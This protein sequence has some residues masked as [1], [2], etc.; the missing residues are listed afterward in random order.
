MTD[1]PLDSYPRPWFYRPEFY[2]PFFIFPPVWSVLTLR[3]PWNSNVLMGG[4]A[5]FVLAASVVLSFNWGYRQGNWHNLLIFLPGLLLT[6]AT[7]VQWQAHLAQHGPP[8]AAGNDAADPARPPAVTGP[9]DGR[10]SRPSARR[11]PRRRRKG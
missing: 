9:G 7:Q 10:P 6:V 5:W 8:P 3:S 11:R 4:V 2:I 1:D